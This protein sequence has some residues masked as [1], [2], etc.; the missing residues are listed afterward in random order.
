M[1]DIVA[2]TREKAYRLA[3]ASY[4]KHQR[5]D[6]L[7]DD[8]LKTTLEAFE[9]LAPKLYALGPVFLLAA[10]ET[11][12]IAIALRGYSEARKSDKKKKTDPQ[13]SPVDGCTLPQNS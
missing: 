9:E 11:Q 3:G 1:G 2:E 12:R 5:G 10:I 13:G 6:S 7:T 8:E 4:Y